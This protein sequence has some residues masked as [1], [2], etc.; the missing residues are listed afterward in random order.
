MSNAWWYALTQEEKDEINRKKREAHW[1]MREEFG[2]DNRRGRV[3]ETLCWSCQK[4]VKECPWSANF[5]P[6]D[7]WD[8][9]ETKIMTHKGVLDSYHVRKCPLYLPDPPEPKKE[10]RRK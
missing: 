7:G 8:A 4:A 5:E 10:K 9:D 1:K 3:P 2:F 6:V